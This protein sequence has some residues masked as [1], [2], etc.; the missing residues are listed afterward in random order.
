MTETITL[1]SE[2]TGRYVADVSVFQR[3]DGLF[4]ATV[5]YGVLDQEPNVHDFLEPF[6]RK[7][8]GFEA[9]REWAIAKL[10]E[11]DV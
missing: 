8:Q 5:T 10:R 11:L 7:D 1:T 9:A 3:A 2:M 4:G 6:A